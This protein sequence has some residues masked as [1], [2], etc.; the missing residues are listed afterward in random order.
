MRLVTKEPRRMLSR[1]DSNDK[2]LWQRCMIAA[3]Q[4]SKEQ[5]GRVQITLRAV[6]SS[7]MV[8][9]LWTYI[10]DLCQNPNGI[11]NTKRGPTV[12]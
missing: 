1:L 11:Y 7:C 6:I 4:E 3:L 10:G 9:Q 8:F 12:N 5:T 2:T